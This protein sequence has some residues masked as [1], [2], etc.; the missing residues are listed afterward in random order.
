MIKLY[1]LFQTFPSFRLFKGALALLAV[2]CY[3]PPFMENFGSFLNSRE[4]E[5]GEVGDR[6][7]SIRQKLR[8][9][10]LGHAL[11]SQLPQHR[12]QNL[13]PCGVLATP[14]LTHPI[15]AEGKWS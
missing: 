12:L 11:S 8:R 6:R 15:C 1:T 3:F 14:T 7:S 4:I 5:P 2:S 9:A 13:P 10:G